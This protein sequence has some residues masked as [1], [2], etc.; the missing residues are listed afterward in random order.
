MAT[1]SFTDRFIVK[2]ADGVERELN[3]NSGSLMWLK[4]VHKFDLRVIMTSNLDKNATPEQIQADNKQRIEAINDNIDFVAIAG[5]MD[6]KGEWPLVGVDLVRTMAPI[7]SM[8][9]IVPVFK[10]ALRDLNRKRKTTSDEPVETADP[11]A[12]QPV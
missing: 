6:K 7:D 10:A 2:F 11:N 3:Y 9:L 5:C 12:P 8:E 1:D 4:R